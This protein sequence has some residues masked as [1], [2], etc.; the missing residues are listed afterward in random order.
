MSLRYTSMLLG[1]RGTSNQQLCIVNV[2]NMW[3]SWSSFQ[4]LT[5]VQP[6]IALVVARPEKKAAK[7]EFSQ[8]KAGHV[9]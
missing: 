7:T 1:R 8:V 4:A 6:E 3:C 9:F 5:P 2:I